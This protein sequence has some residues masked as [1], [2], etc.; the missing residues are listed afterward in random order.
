MGINYYKNKKIGKKEDIR[1]TLIN[2]LLLEK[3]GLRTHQ[4]AKN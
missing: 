2:Y 3:K 1:N 4:A